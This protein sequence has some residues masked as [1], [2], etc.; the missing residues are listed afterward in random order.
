M[1]VPKL[2]VNLSFQIY[3]FAGLKKN[4]TYLLINSINYEVK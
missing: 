1:K 2:S 4:E 3:Y